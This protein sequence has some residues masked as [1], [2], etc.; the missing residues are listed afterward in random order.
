M[1]PLFSRIDG[2]DGDWSQLTGDVLVAGVGGNPTNVAIR[3]AADIFEPAQPDTSNPW[4]AAG[5]VGGVLA[6][7]AALVAALLMRRR[8]SRGSLRSDGAHSADHQ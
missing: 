8:G 6:L 4:L 7:I 1:D 5:I 3:P 2:V